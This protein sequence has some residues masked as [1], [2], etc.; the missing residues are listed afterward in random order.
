[1]ITYLPQIKDFAT[2]IGIN[3]IFDQVTLLNVGSGGVI[4]A[5]V[6]AWLV[7]K[8]EKFVRKHIYHNVDMIVTPLIS[9]LV[10]T[11]PYV[12]IIMPIAGTFSNLIAMGVEST[13]MSTNVIVRGIAG[14]VAAALFLPLVAMGMHHALIPI[15]TV[16]LSTIGYISL[17]PAL[18][19]GG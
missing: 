6:G 13:I 19:M 5:I 17:Y 3:T 14:F 8:V 16:Q 2:A 9:I 15:Y 10:V 7:C 1:M 4:A 18:C 12:L 11:I